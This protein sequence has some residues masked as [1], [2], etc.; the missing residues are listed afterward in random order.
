MFGRFDAAYGS[1]ET[2]KSGA[3]HLHGQFFLQ[4]HHQFHPLREL[5]E[6][7]NEAMLELLRKYSDYSAYVTRKVYCD[8]E[9]WKE[10]RNALE[11]EWPEFRRGRCVLFVTYKCH[12]LWK[13]KAKS[14]RKALVREVVRTRKL[15][16][17]SRA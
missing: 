17:G 6:M 8:P 12:D 2:Q 14:F 16:A 4:C 5:V 3:F 9:T 10:Q 15:P 7:G 13:G 1:I 11:A